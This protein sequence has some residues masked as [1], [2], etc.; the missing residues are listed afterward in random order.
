MHIWDMAITV[1]WRTLLAIVL[2]AEVFTLAATFGVP[3]LQG[4]VYSDPEFPRLI[5]FE[6][7]PPGCI[8]NFR[9]NFFVS[10]AESTVLWI[11]IVLI[12]AGLRRWIRSNDKRVDQEIARLHSQGL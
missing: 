1:K 6:H 7:N 11:C 8:I 5:V 2:F 10:A 4:K 12:V 9:G 3:A